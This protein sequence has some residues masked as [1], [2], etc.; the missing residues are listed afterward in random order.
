MNDTQRTAPTGSPTLAR[1]RPE[2]E[3]LPESHIVA[4][5]QLGF[6]VEDVVGLWVG[7]GDLPT[8]KFI[9]DAAAQSL[10]NGETFYT[11]KR[12]L[13]EL[14]Q[15]IATYHE[16]LHGHAVD[17]ERVIV[18]SAGMSAIMLATQ[19]IIGRGDNGIVVSPIWPNAAAAMRIV[20]AEVREVGLDATPSGWKLDIARL[21][22]ACDEN[23]RAIYIATPGNPTGWLAES[24]EIKAIMDLARRR[25]IW[26]VAD[27]VYNRFVYDRPPGAS[28]VTSAP[29]FLA[30]AAQDDPLIVVHSFSKAWAMTGWRMGWMIAPERLGTTIDKLIEYNTSGAQPFLQRACIVAIEQGEGF[31]AEMV[32][33]CRRARDLTI[34][35]L[36]AMKRVH[37]VPAP[38][39]FYQMFSI[40]G[41]GD[42]LE[43]AKRMVREARVGLA[44]GS[45]FGQGGEKHFRLCYACSTERISKAMDRLEAFLE[46]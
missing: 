8:P 20:G 21:E 12:G 30:E 22:A 5:W 1:I 45:A 41:S 17:V 6:E 26:A 38:A 46:K 27:E 32:E 28:G 39:A 34:Q 44:P 13:P 7:E 31:V 9:C 3:E 15:A 11:Y 25:G 14:R 23:T 42:T 35:R 24:H 33:R 37:L 43:F 40:D 18:T 16:G 29:S 10:A 19:A 36:S 4:V 2:M